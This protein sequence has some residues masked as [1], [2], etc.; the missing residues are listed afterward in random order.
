MC[1]CVCVC[2]CVKTPMSDIGC[3]EGAGWSHGGFDAESDRINE[4]A[5][6]GRPPQLHGAPLQTIGT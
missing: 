1:V 5:T 6:M 3:L 2:V 4:R